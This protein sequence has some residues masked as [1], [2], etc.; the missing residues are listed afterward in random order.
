MKHKKWAAAGGLLAAA[1]G[2]LIPIT[3]AYLTSD[4]E[5]YNRI[6]MPENKIE[7][8]EDFTEPE[9]L[10]PGMEIPKNP[11]VRNT[12]NIPVFV[13]MRA[14]FSSG[15]MKDRCEPLE[16][17]PGW[18]YSEEDQFYYYKKILLPQE[19]SDPLFQKIR[20][21]EDVPEDEMQDFEILVYSES[22]DLDGYSGEIGEVNE[23][24]FRKEWDGKN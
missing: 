21:R 4:Q 18:F 23:E 16:I 9:E 15:D 24:G 10:K 22:K 20:I 2:I 19:E 12:G 1:A 5:V 7:I 3:R 14:E 17:S 13:R 11:S 6:R 8:Q